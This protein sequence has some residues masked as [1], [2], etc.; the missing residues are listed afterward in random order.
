MISQM[1][2]VVT[3]HQQGAVVVKPYGD[4]LCQDAERETYTKYYKT[5]YDSCAIA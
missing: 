1:P 5:A 2:V 3:S 4:G